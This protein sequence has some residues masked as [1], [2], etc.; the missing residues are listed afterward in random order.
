MRCLLVS[1][2]TYI[3]TQ[4]IL[5]YL[6]QPKHSQDADALTITMWWLM[7][8][9]I[10]HAFGIRKGAYQVAQARL[11]RIESHHLL[12][13]IIIG[14]VVLRMVWWSSPLTASE[15]AWRYVWDGA[16]QWKQAPTYLYP[17][18]HTHMDQYIQNDPELAIIRSQIGHGDIATIYPPMAQ[19]IFKYAYLLSPSPLGIRI[20][21]VGFELFLMIGLVAIL[22]VLRHNP[23]WVATYALHPLMIFEAGHGTHLDAWGA[24][25]MIWG[26]Y[27]YLL[28]KTS[29]SVILLTIGG[30]IKLVPWIIVGFIAI[31]LY[32][33]NPTDRIS[34]YQSIGGGVL[35]SFVCCIP[36]SQEFFYLN[37][38][39]GLYAYTTRWSFNEGLFA[40][41]QKS[42]DH[43][44]IVLEYMLSVIASYI[45][46]YPKTF[47]WHIQDYTLICTKLIL[48]IVFIWLCLYK[49]NR[50]HCIIRA[51]LYAIITLLLISPVVFS[52][53][54]TWIIALMPLALA[55][56]EECV[57]V[58]PK[59]KLSPSH[60]HAPRFA[61][62]GIWIYLWSIMIPL[63]YL[64]RV[65]L[66][67]DHKWQVDLWWIIL[68]YT[69]L[70][71][72][73]LFITRYTSFHS[74]TQ[75]TQNVG[76]L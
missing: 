38:D 63:S 3:I 7:I 71:L 51:S 28:H 43:L 5:I 20:V 67:K 35:V 68:E 23:L 14:G 75:P 52:W 74:H 27:F 24:C 19:I 45:L 42:L 30:W 22:K 21:L 62:M 59:L 10:V 32:K 26:L 16:M 44:F 57:D 50:E 70:W 17:P 4:C 60:L 39:H 54:L 29:I 15:D 18:H 47:S 33:Q 31:R 12:V 72:T 65:H 34:F 48:A 73:L 64:P 8:S 2:Y 53:Y 11:N 9:S 6:V 55:S 41:L 37:R 76:Q 25:F 46:S 13:L 58:S 1:I 49:W 36:F 69:L 40:V 61:W 56:F 66:L